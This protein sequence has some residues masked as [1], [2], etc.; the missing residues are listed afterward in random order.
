[1]QSLAVLVSL[2]HTNTHTHTHKHTHTHTLTLPFT[3]THTHTHALT[4]HTHSLISVH[5]AMHLTSSYLL[6]FSDIDECEEPGPCDHNC[7]NTIGSYTCSCYDGYRGNTTD[8]STCIGG[9]LLNIVKCVFLRSLTASYEPL[10]FIQK[11]L[12]TR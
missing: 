3:H 12:F 4:T 8:N 7:A 9:Q 10:L 1:M 5:K 2:S 6:S 11:M